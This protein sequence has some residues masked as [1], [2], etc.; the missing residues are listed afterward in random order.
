[1][2]IISLPIIIIPKKIKAFAIG[3]SVILLAIVSI[4]S[5]PPKSKNDKVSAKENVEVIMPNL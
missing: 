5:K 1:M 4:H 3:F 2:V